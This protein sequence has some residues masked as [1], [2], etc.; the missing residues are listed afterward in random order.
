MKYLLLLLFCFPGLCKSQTN[1]VSHNS[2]QG[3]KTV[4]YCDTCASAKIS[5]DT[6]FLK[7][8]KEVTRNDTVKVLMLLTDTSEYSGTMLNGNGIVFWQIGYEILSGRYVCCDPKDKTN[9]S[10]Y[11]LYTHLA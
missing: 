6:L 1:Q 3:F 7:G 5:N 4:V 10:Y 11:W 8:T 9:S 2:Q